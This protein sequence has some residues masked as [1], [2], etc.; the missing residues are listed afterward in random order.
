MSCAG[1]GDQPY[2]ERRTGCP[3]CS[4]PSHD[5]LATVRYRDTAEANPSLPDIAGTLFNCAACGIAFPSHVYNPLTFPLLYAK[6]LTDLSYLD[7]SPIQRLR[8][9]IIKEI[10]RNRNLA[11][12]LST[13]LDAIS[14]RVLQVPELKRRPQNLQILDVGCGFGEFLEI[15]K[16]LG[17]FVVGT[18]IVPDLVTQLRRRGFDIRDGEVETLD[19][20]QGAFDVIV[21]RAVFYRTRNPVT[22]LGIVKRAL[23]PDGELTLVDPCPG[24]DGVEY[25]FRKQF[26]QGQFYIMDVASY[27]RMLNG[28]FQ[29]RCATSRIIHGRPEALLKPVR[30][31]GNLLGLAE[32]LAANIFGNRPY[33]LNYNLKPA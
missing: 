18:E 26:P 28:R 1:D 22:T 6:S 13:L 30:F 25:F 10:L 24:R 12:S 5:V 14:L 23:A 16:S 11:V 9:A 2:F 3:F 27:L 29:L 33:V 15:F 8:K 20:P 31:F 17:N 7:Q 4:T 21:M 19:L 32:L